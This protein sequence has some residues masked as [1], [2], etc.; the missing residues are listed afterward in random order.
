M[1]GRNIFFAAL[2]V[3]LAGVVLIITYQTI[4]SVGVVITGGILFMLAGLINMTGAMSRRRKD[5]V[6]A[7]SYVFTMITSVA[8]MI[9][10]LCLLLFQ[11]TFTPLVPFIFGV[12]IACGALY[13]FFFLGYGCRPATCPWW[14]Y[15]VPIAMVGAA[16]Y[17]FIQRPEDSDPVIML[18]TGISLVVMGVAMVLESIFV[19]R[20][21]HKTIEAQKAPKP[22]ESAPAESTAAATAAPEAPAQPETDKKAAEHAAPKPLDPEL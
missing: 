18:V 11:S 9:L 7:V 12:L 17:L 21:N 5:R 16:V 3:L 10:G 1:K 20:Y 15:I 14:L 4:K 19:G 22:V 8:A 13:Q 6:G 2:L